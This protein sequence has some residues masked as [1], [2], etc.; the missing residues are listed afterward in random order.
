MLGLS[1]DLRPRAATAA[2]GGRGGHGAR[3]RSSRPRPSQLFPYSGKSCLGAPPFSFALRPLFGPPFLRPSVRGLR[4]R[5]YGRVLRTGNVNTA[6]P[7]MAA[8]QAAMA[9]IEVPACG[10][11]PGDFQAGARWPVG[12]A[13]LRSRLC[14]PL[15]GGDGQQSPSPSRPR[16]CVTVGC[17][18][19]TYTSLLSASQ[20]SL[21]QPYP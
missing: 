5:R 15:E 12:P 3:K 1:P 21:S 6:R 17:P 18:Q 16:R 11:Q 2:L 10:C 14:Q 9:V 20:P 19:P 7:A 8:R 4:Y 13:T